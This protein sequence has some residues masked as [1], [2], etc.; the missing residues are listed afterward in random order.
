MRIT[1]GDVKTTLG[2]QNSY[3]IVNAIRNSGSDTFRQYVPLASA[4]NVAEVGAGILVNQA[5]QNE[6]IASLI[7]RIGLTVVRNI[8]LRNPLK[9]FKKG[10]LPMGRTIQEIFVDIAEEHMYDPD[11]AEEQVFKR[12][13]PD[14]KSLFHERN[15]QGFYKR[16]VQDE[17]LKSAFIS[18]GTFEDFTTRI[19]NSIYNSAEVDEF[20][21]MKLVIDNYA[22]KGL[23]RFEKV[24]DP[25]TSEVFAKDFVK[26]IRATAQKMTLPMGSRDFNASGVHTV[27]SM[28][29]LHLI[30]DA[31]IQ[32]QIDVEVL[33]SAFNM[34]KV[35]FVGHVTV[36][37]N[38]ATTGLKAVLVDEDWFMVYDTLHKMETIRNPQGL[39]WNFYYHVWQVLSASRFG[40][41]VAFITDASSIPDVTQV[42]VS[43]EVASLKAG[44]SI[45]YEGIIRQTDD[46]SRTITWSVEGKDGTSVLTGTK[47]DA[48]GLLTTDASQTGRLTI[49]ATVSYGE[50]QTCI[51][52]AVLTVY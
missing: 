24:D 15:R 50:S 45:Q 32:A 3:D 52:E 23:F 51:G 36:I 48:N 37:D 17:S 2:I 18:W 46:V 31:D 19:V 21:Y 33:A 20:K 7:D 35:E 47:I 44:N 8:S 42:I 34:S 12:E 22:S 41:A 49:K 38:F 30:I 11:T 26:R 14:V 39:Y 43:P 28:D 9:K 10:S 13:L 6:F 1:F 25:T 40:N 16:T 29:K 4:D 27:T 5:V